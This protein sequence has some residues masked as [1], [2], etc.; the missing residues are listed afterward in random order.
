MMPVHHRITLSLVLI[1]LGLTG[2]SNSSPDKHAATN[3]PPAATKENAQPEDTEKQATPQTADATLIE[4][5][6]GLRENRSAVIWNALPESYQQDIN[7]L[8]HEFSE[9]M[10]PELWNRTI[11]VGQKLTH[12]L[13]TR[14][15]DI[16][17]HA[18]LKQIAEPSD[19]LIPVYDGLTN[20]LAAL[21]KSD[22]SDL[23]RMKDFQG[24]E[25]FSSLS[26]DEATALLYALEF[27]HTNPFFNILNQLPDDA[28]ITSE[29]ID[30][31]T[32]LVKLVPKTGEADTLDFVKVEGKWIPKTWAENWKQDIDQA[33]AQF[34]TELDPELLKQKKQRTLPALKKADET[35]NQLQAAESRDTFHA[36]LD[37]QIGPLMAFLKNPQ[38]PQADAPVVTDHPTENAPAAEGKPLTIVLN[39]V[40]NEKAEST[41]ADKLL[42]AIE[43]QDL[44]VVE[45][46]IAETRTTRIRVFP[47]A[48]INAF[49]KRLTFVTVLA[50]NEKTRTIT[51]EPKE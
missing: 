43:N 39:A 50:I 8:T 36:L 2:C 45:P 29:Q 7:D 30:D 48:D 40:L 17:S 9:Q 16:L 41:L 4:I 14:K 47:V 1:L 3:Q 15:A 5:R 26:G 19:A 12:L 6:I 21:L 11:L 46:P 23:N 10:D 27:F 24:K 33:H 32:A 22:L 25:F 35:I 51:I 44:A 13:K 49:A 37:Q 28:R 31:T 20:L 18:S 34:A 38:A 42:D